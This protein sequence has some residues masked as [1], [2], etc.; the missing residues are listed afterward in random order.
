MWLSDLLAASACGPQLALSRD[1]HEA[2]PNLWYP[3][4]QGGQS[5]GD[6]LVAFQGG[7]GASVPWQLPGLVCRAAGAV[8]VAPVTKRSV[9]LLAVVCCVCKHVLLGR[10]TFQS[11]LWEWGLGHREFALGGWRCW[12]SPVDL[13]PHGRQPALPCLLERCG[14]APFEGGSEAQGLGLRDS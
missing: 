6:Y 9:S 7:S 2:S 12:P 4:M 3:Q 8:G 11:H 14:H 13:P 10:S 1:K 5:T